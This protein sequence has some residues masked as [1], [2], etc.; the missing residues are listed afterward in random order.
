M[1][2][3][4]LDA[5]RD[6]AQ[7]QNAIQNLADTIEGDPGGLDDYCRLIDGRIKGLYRSAAGLTAAVEVVA[8]KWG[9]QL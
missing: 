8:K 7:F 2:R 9:V 3:S 4:M 5:Y 6:D 1:P